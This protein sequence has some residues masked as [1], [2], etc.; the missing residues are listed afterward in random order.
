[1]M[2][3]VDDLNYYNIIDKKEKKD[4]VKRIKAKYN[5]LILVD[6]LRSRWRRLRRTTDGR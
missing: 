2:N 4:H 3:F 6:K 5:K 1:M